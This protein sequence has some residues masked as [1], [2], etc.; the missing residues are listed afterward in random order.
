MM[1]QDL[2]FGQHRIDE[3]ST[4]SSNAR[5]L[6]V[7]SQMS[8]ESEFRG[9]LPIVTP[10]AVLSANS[11]IDDPLASFTDDEV[12]EEWVYNVAVERLR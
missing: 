8:S 6:L 1:G 12:S 7:T 4:P 5:T 9:K 3:T 11:D 10:V 2:V